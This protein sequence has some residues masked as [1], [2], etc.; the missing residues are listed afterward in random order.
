MNMLV[1]PAPL[2][3]ELD[4]GYLG[5]IMRINGYRSPK[6]L[7][8]VAATHFG[9]EDRTRREFTTHECLSRFA[10]MS[11]EEF[12]RRHTTLPLRRGITSYFPDV[13]H[14]SEERRSLLFNSA[15][16]RKCH[17]AFFCKECV[18]ADVHFH[19]VSYWRRDLQTPGQMW[20][21]KH[22]KPLHYVSCADPFISSPAS[23]GEEAIQIPEG[24]VTHAINHVY[25]QRF[26]ELTTTLYD[27][28]VPLSVALIAP[29]LR[30]FGKAQGFK[31]NSSSTQGTLISDQIKAL[32]PE[33]WLEVVFSEVATK[34]PGV[35]LHQIDGTMYLRTAASSV[36]GYL[37]VLSVLFESADQA[38]NA[39]RAVCVG[40]VTPVT[41]PRK[42]G[43]RLPSMDE[44][45][46]Q[47]ADA[48]G[49]HADVARGLQLPIH[50][51]RKSLLDIGLPSLP[52]FDST[53]SMGVVAALKAYYIDKRPYLACMRL[54]GLPEECFDELMRQCGPAVA[55]AIN[56]MLP[57]Q[58]RRAKAKRGLPH[59]LQAAAAIPIDQTPETLLQN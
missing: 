28:P 58:K 2:P 26:I 31:I 18:S 40:D 57:K 49:V 19:G 51:V 9:F 1:Q 36:I 25:V 55:I 12:A 39:L 54:S 48:K 4:R 50:V 20:C 37:L 14:G 56:L 7:L 45:V 23:L 33:S 38:I 52:A 42:K 6:D 44:L 10:S 41:R 35:Y 21:P 17:A 27:R 16:L 43:R 3:D 46:Q 5:R 13:A 8:D 11:S 29:L 32:F 59:R 24:W 22:L 53:L 34:A 15:T 30:D 47:Y